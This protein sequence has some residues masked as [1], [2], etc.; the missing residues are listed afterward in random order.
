MF[1]FVFV[2]ALLP[3]LSLEEVGVN[4]F[5]L[6]HFSNPLPPFGICE[7]TLFGKKK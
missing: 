7:E 1:V 4:L 3:S 6:T 5:I 2:D